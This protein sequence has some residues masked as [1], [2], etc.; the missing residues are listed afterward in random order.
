MKGESEGKER[1]VE[2][3]KLGRE[4]EKKRAG[5]TTP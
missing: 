4:R 1:E 2:R 5:G 3:Q